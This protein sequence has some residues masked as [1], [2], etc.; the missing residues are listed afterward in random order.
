MDEKTVKIK[1]RIVEGAATDVVD[2][3]SD[4]TKE[5]FV[6]Y[7]GRNGSEK[8]SDGLKSISE[9]NRNPEYMNQNTKQQAGFSAEIKSVARKNAD[10]IIE[11]KDGRFTRTDDIA[12]R[13][14]DP[15]VDV[16]EKGNGSKMIEAQMKFVG[17]NADALL[18]YFETNKKAQKYLDADVL[19][20]IPDDF[21]DELMEKN[22]GIAKQLES[23]EKQL[24]KAIERG[25]SEQE[26]NIKDR[27]DKLKKIKK[28][29]RKSGVTNEEAI[30]ARNH[31]KLSTIKDVARISHKAGMRGAE[32][33][34][35]CTGGI[36]LI[37]NFVSYAKGEIDAKEAGMAIAKD[38]GTSA[39]LGYATAFSGSAINGALKNA[40]SEYLRSLSK[41]NL[42]SNL[43]V[44]TK[45]VAFTMAALVRGE[46]DGV[47]CIERLGKEGFGEIGAAMFSAASVAAVGGLESTVVTVLAGVAGSTVG[48]MAAVAVYDELKNALEEYKFAKEERIRIEA[49]CEE[50]IALIRYYRQEMNAKVEEYLSEHM[51][52]FEE[53]FSKMDDAILENDINGF[54]SGNV[55]IQQC[56][57]RDVQFSN[58]EEF[59][60]LMSSSDSLVL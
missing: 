18:E 40:S 43:V 3:F 7:A 4:A 47:E 17:K 60:E 58:M 9:R 51:S 56:M 19:L 59:D 10:N 13:R 27:I 49:E 33:A 11:G 25:N 37:R 6:A 46:I 53:G 16:V 54:I 32:Y 1:D 29:L 38:T 20:D 31:P 55:A 41:T 5:H 52:T 2:R 44:T 45:N 28:N 24:D 39:A 57:G 50:A 26:K 12:G 34:A 15:I 30:E 23:Y 48:Y 42:A 8:L 14:N 21:Y 36:S 35:I 22:G